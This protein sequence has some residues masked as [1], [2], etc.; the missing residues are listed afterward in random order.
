MKKQTLMHIGL[1]GS[2]VL[3]L[4][5]CKDAP[6]TK[7]SINDS[8]DNELEPRATN[9][10]LAQQASVGAREDGNLYASHFNGAELNSLGKQ[11][12]NLMSSGREIGK[13]KVFLAVPKDADYAGREGAVSSYL[14]SCGLTTDAFSITAGPNP[15]S[16][17]YAADGLKALQ[18]T[19]GA[20][21]GGA[22]DTTA[23]TPS[24]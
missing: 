3:G 15:N 5:G 19:E 16:K 20:A 14:A 23:A 13:L 11:K 17:S 24:K 1:M 18:Q 7:W 21:S 9:T 10:I 6:A 22:G 4:A 2:L 12:L 8:F